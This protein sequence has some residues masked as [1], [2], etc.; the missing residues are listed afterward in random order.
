MWGE[1]AFKSGR[2]DGSQDGQRERRNGI[3]DLN[4]SKTQDGNIKRTFVNDKRLPAD[5]IKWLESET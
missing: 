1:T 5:A 3:I 4:I 2:A